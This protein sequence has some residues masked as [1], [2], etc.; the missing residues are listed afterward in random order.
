MLRCSRMRTTVTL[1]PDTEALIRRRMRERGVSFKQAL[2]DTIR[3]GARE[4]SRAHTF[5][6]ATAELGMPV[7]NLDGALRVAADIED[8]E[9]VRK[10]RVGK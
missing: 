10:M 7:V 1:D 5:A 2:N 6:T 8:E 3:E 9:L 4:T